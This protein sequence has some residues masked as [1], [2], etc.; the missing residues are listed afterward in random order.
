MDSEGLL[1]PEGLWNRRG[2]WLA[3]SIA[4][5]GFIGFQYSFIDQTMAA[6]AIFAIAWIVLLAAA[7]LVALFGWAGAQGLV[8]LRRPA[9]ALLSRVPASGRLNLASPWL[10]RGATTVWRAARAWLTQPVGPWKWPRVEW[11]EV[12]N[13][14]RIEELGRGRGPSAD[15][16]PPHHRRAA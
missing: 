10:A 12:R 15:S 2:A 6:F 1:N 5:A 3:G 4:A 11:A 14:S 16:Q 7:F 9:E 8:R 13:I